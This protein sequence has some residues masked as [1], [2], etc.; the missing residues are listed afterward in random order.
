[1]VSATEWLIRIRM[2]LG[3]VAAD[4]LRLQ[5][6]RA[7]DRNRRSALLSV[8]SVPFGGP[9]NRAFDNHRYSPWST[10]APQ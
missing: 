10:K 3:V 5:L 9:L 4:A 8:L 1:M 2:R 6:N 7:F